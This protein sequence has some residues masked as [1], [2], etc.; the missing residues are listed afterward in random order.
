MVAFLVGNWRRGPSVVSS[1]AAAIEAGAPSV[2]QM[3][4]D[5]HPGI[6][7]LA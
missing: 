3:S 5:C 1:G 2:R 4:V 6:S 7:G